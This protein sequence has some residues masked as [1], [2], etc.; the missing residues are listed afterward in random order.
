[1]Y[2]TYLQEESKEPDVIVQNGQIIIE[3]PPEHRISFPSKPANVVVGIGRSYHEDSCP[4]GP[5]NIVLAKQK[6]RNQYN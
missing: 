6:L 4:D 1:M 5:A 2:N 3:R